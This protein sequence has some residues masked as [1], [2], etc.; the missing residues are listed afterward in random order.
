M[1]NAWKL[2]ATWLTYG[3]LVLA[4]G[5]AMLLGKADAVLVER[6][7]VQVA[8]VVAPILESVSRPVDRAA[9]VVASSRRL[10]DLAAEN[11]ALRQEREHLLQW[12]AVAQRL[13]A[14]NAQLRGLLKLVAE[15]E[16][17]FVAGRVVADPGGAYANSLLVNAG[18]RDGVDK[19]HIVLT[20][21]GLVG[22]IAASA[23]RVSRVLLISDLNSRV[24]V[25]VGEGR[26][27]AILAG[28]N[29]FYPRLIHLD[30]DEKIAA[31]DHVVTSG[32][33]EAF[34]P[35]LPVGTVVSVEHGD[36]RVAPFVKQTRLEFVRVVDHRLPALI[37]EFLAARTEAAMLPRLQLPAATNAQ[38]PVSAPVEVQT[39]G[40]TAPPAVVPLPVPRPAGRI[41]P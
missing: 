26:A 27:R 31:G 1:W 41:R 36:V 35:G 34:P 6:L 15:P 33:T 29:S 8:D 37:D 7:R 38:L 5:A 13:E 14:E 17:R 18:Q 24:P 40:A 20:G 32:I 21:E 2:L 16:A 3:V 11:S 22:R 25:L 4:A 19:G 30:P 12:Q 28:D 10:V 39:E 9:D 23:N